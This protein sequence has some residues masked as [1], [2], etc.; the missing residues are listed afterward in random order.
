MQINQGESDNNL[1]K[2][3]QSFNLNSQQATIFEVQKRI[4]IVD[5]EPYNILS[6]TTQLT[7]MGFS[8]I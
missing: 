6:L 2:R 7:Q 3:Y 4:L 8:G 5:D 1:L